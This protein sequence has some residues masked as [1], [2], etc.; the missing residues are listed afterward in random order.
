MCVCAFVQVCV[1]ER[2]RKRE[3]ET[4]DATQQV[5]VVDNASQGKARVVYIGLFTPLYYAIAIM[6]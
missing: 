3:E 1:L 2:G 5:S 6:T 4:R